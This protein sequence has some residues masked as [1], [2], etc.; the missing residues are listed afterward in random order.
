V[1]EVIPVLEVEASP[2]K[3]VLDR[4]DGRIPSAFPTWRR[5]AVGSAT[6]ITGK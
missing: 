1:G 2:G 5:L 3:G 6:V 4:L